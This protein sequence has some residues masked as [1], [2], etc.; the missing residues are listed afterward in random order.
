MARFL[1]INLSFGF[2]VIVFLFPSESVAVYVPDVPLENVLRSRNLFQSMLNKPAELLRAYENHSWKVSLR[3]PKDVN[4][5]VE[6]VEIFY[7]Q[8]RIDREMDLRDDESDAQRAL[9]IYNFVN[10]HYQQSVPLY[11]SK[12]QHHSPHFLSVFGSGLCD[13]SAANIVYLA[14]KNGFEARSWWF[15]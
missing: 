10:D 8:S 6:D 14:Q 2:I 4:V 11:E 15:R 13:D 9:K 12:V 1:R 7:S 5:R 3:N